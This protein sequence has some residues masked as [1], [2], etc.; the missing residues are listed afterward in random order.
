MPIPIL[1]LIA[2]LRAQFQTMSIM[3]LIYLFPPRMSLPAITKFFEGWDTPNKCLRRQIFC[4][5]QVVQVEELLQSKGGANML[6]ICHS[7]EICFR[8]ISLINIYIKLV[9]QQVHLDYIPFLVNNP[10]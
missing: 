9:D 6:V 10:S 7:G 3:L 4:L 1:I 2:L 5:E 8:S